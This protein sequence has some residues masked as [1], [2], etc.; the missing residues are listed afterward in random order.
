MRVSTE[1]VAS[2]D[3]EIRQLQQ[4]NARLTDQ[5]GKLETEL[6]K[7]ATTMTIPVPSGAARVFF[8]A[9]GHAVLVTS[10]VPRGRYDL[11]IEGNA[12]PLVTIDVPESGEKAATIKNMPPQDTI[13]A[14]TL[15][16]H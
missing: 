5:V 11:R 7:T 2:R 8:E 14:F 9:S 16:A 4:E 6:A 15:T 3:A 1:K 10:D 12:K 13:K